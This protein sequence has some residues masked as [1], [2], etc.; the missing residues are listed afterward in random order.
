MKTKNG[1]IS[2]LRRMC[3]FENIAI[4]FFW[5]WSI[6]MLLI[7]A[8]NLNAG[9]GFSS[10]IISL[11]YLIL[12]ILVVKFR[13]KILIFLK[14]HQK[15]TMIIC[16]IMIIG[17]ILLRFGLVL[18]ENNFYVEPILSDTGVHWQGSAQL[19]ETGQLNKDIGEY[20]GIFPYLT[21]YTGT[22]ALAMNVFGVGF[23]AVVLSNTFF[24]IISM[25]LIFMLFTLWKSNKKAGLMAATIWAINP[26]QIIFCSLPMAIVVTNTMILLVIFLAYLLFRYGREKL[27]LGLLLFGLCGIN[28]AIG[29]AFRPLFTVFMIAIIIFEL[30]LVIRK[31]VKVVHVALGVVMMLLGFGLTNN[32]LSNRISSINP[33]YAMGGG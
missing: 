1:N 14:K 33:Y 28:L 6:L 13:K 30:C 19:V 25:I 5:L 29:N 18:A 23:K 32:V 20:E 21:T 22:L 24:D 31:K 9:L 26:L 7:V 8:V 3:T 2:K 27:W 11:I 10:F 15:G 4:M 12:L 17:G 16:A